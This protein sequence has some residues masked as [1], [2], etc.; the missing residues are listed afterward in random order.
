MI[1]SKLFLISVVVLFQAA[2]ISLGGLLLDQ[3]NEAMYTRGYG[4]QQGSWT[5]QEFRPTMNT[6]EQVDFY[7]D[8]Y[9]VPVP[10]GH[11]VNFE[12]RKDNDT[13]LWDSSFS[14]DNLPSLGWF[15]LDTPLISLVPGQTYRLCLTST[16]PYSNGMYDFIW[17]GTEGDLYERGD[18]SVPLQGFD[19]RF[20]TWAVPEPT[21][22]FLLGLGTLMLRRKH[23]A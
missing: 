10:E 11:V 19:F 8:N 14:P 2:S 3:A 5:S 20:R 4:I 22:F 6:L 21:T 9:T 17:V 23:R 15:E 7:F 18:A 13:V 16:I 12:L 1:R